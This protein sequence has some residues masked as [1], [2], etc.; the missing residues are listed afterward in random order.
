MIIDPSHRYHCFSPCLGRSSGEA[1]I[2]IITGQDNQVLLSGRRSV[3]WISAV[4]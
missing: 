4:S 3:L 2:V 1:D